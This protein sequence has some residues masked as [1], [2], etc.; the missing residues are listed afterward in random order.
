[1]SDLF[2]HDGYQ[3][4][5]PLLITLMELSSIVNRSLKCHP[6]QYSRYVRTWFLDTSCDD[7]PP[8]EPFSWAIPPK[9]YRKMNSTDYV[10]SS[11]FYFVSVII[12]LQTP[13]RN[14]ILLK[15]PPLRSIKMAST[16]PFSFNI[17]S[18]ICC[19]PLGN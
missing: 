10:I 18:N 6:F 3:R 7:S 11:K 17:N 19:T 15:S 16:S 1:M 5:L 2:R 9:R 12:I 14:R 13:C 8:G 4:Q